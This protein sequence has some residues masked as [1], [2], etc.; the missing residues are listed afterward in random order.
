[1]NVQEFLDVNVKDLKEKTSLPEEKIKE[2]VEMWSKSPMLIPR[3]V[4]VTVNMSLGEG[5]ERLAKA[6]KVLEE[7][8]GQKPIFRKAKRTIRAFGIRKG[9]NIA[10][11]VTLRKEKAI[12]FLNKAFEAVGRRIKTSSIDAHGNVSFGIEE[13]I[14]IPGVKYDPEI[15]ILGM[16]VAITV[17]RPGYRIARRKRTKREHIPE[18]HR[19]KPEET[20]ILLSQLLGVTW[21]GR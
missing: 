6:A 16:D 10:V 1:M 9:E 18:R 15:G 14:L 12:E 8:T 4:K 20:M 19:V 17:E 3:I 2:I 21:V 13:H 11:M 7:I 5:G